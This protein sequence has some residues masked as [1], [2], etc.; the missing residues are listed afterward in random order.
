[1]SIY[2]R[3]STWWTRITM[4]GKRYYD[5]CNTSDKKQAQEFH[6]QRKA[7]LWREARLGERKER[8]IEDTFKKWLREHSGKRSALD[9]KRHSEWWLEK[10]K[11]EKITLLSD[12][13]AD[14]VGDIRDE[15]MYSFNQK[16]KGT[17]KQIAPATVNRKL[18][19][20]RTVLNA[21]HREYEWIPSAPKIRMLSEDNERVRWLTP[22]E[23]QRLVKALPE[24]YS[25]M[26]ELAVATGL[27]QSN[28]YGLRWEDVNLVNKTLT[29]PKKVMK[30]GQPFTIPLNQMGLNVVKR[31]IGKHNELV[32]VRKDGYPI[33]GVPTST[34]KK[35]CTKA[36]IE[37]FRWHDLRH[38]WAS[39][40]RQSGKVGLDLIQELG[41]WKSGKMVQRYAH[42]SVE[43]LA[44]SAE[45]LDDVFDVKG[46][47][48]DNSQGAENVTRLV[49]A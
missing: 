38:T 29:F 3:G 36:G 9:D 28:V 10:F 33:N 43:H 27:R 47:I 34:W 18:A 23:L 46:Q 17:Q 48:W 6:D 4:D 15:Y 5:S 11:A 12:V 35:A 44:T 7:E 26:A 31:W 39:L 37:D 20:L 1:M 30:N 14:V 21:A 32:F 40:M 16:L 49:A 19:F 45:V 13:S 24:P 41:G 22:V 2:L 8:T 25:S 42:L